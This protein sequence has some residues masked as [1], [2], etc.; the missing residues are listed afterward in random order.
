[1]PII[2]RP[3]QP[4]EVAVLATP[5]RLLSAALVLLAIEF[6]CILSAQSSTRDELEALKAKVAAQQEQIDELRR[7]LEAQSQLLA[8]V[9]RGPPSEVAPGS[10]A[11]H[12]FGNAKAP[13]AIAAPSAVKPGLAAESKQAPLTLSIGGVALS[14]TGFLDLSQVWRSKTVTSGL[15]TNFASIPFNNTV[16]GNRRQTLSTAANSRIGMQ[17]TTKF[18]SVGLLG[19]LETDFLG[20]LP[21]N[22]STTT[23]SNGMRLR[24]AFADLR[25][26]K[27]EF[28]GGQA[29]SLLTPGRKGISALPAGLNLTQDLDPNNQS[30]MVWARS[31]QAR[32]VYHPK[33]SVAIAVSFESGG[34]YAGGSSGAGA[35]TMPSALA[36]NYFNQ[37]DVGS[38]GLSVPSPNLDLIGKIAFDPK[39]WGRNAH[40]EVAGLMNRFAFY[41]QLTNQRFTVMGGGGSFYAGIDI[42]KNL[43]V[44]TSNFYSNGGGR[45]IYGEAPALIIRGDGAPVLVNAMATLSGAELQARPRLKLWMYYGGTYIDRATVLDPSNSRPV[46]YGYTGS[47]NSHN[48]SIQEVTG[49]FT[50]VFW[51]H[52]DYGTLQLSGQYSWLVRHPWYVANGQPRSANLNMVYL[53]LRYVLPAPPPVSK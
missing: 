11:G 53:G 1:M 48:R 36:P 33:D 6:P 18:Q 28:L 31:P 49:G 25:V 4:E 23:N 37:V 5:K 16:E 34:T 35:I 42:V 26:G 3:G 52:P 24:L 32:V 29:W 30:G 43:M 41:N 47:P 15:P 51:Q 22:V 50:R 2:G 21:G 19:V 17:L 45:L 44:F 20:F 46:G 12:A 13:Q 10:S 7:S 38:G 39:V 40:F 9:L 14:P 27:W 8:R